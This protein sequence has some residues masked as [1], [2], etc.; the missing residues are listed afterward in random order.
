V[1]LTNVEPTHSSSPRCFDSKISI[2]KNA[3]PIWLD[4][5]KLRN[6]QE[7]IGLG[8]V[9]FGVFG[10]YNGVEKIVQAN[11]LENLHNHIVIGTR[12]NPHGMRFAISPRDLNHWFDW[13]DL[14]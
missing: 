7:H 12:A 8:F 13:L 14:G 11:V 4:L 6:F 5:D 9:P 3:T 1:N 2:L 10:S